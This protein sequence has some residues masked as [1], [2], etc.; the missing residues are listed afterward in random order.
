MFQ[1]Q[2]PQPRR[3]IL[4][5]N[6]PKVVLGLGAAIAIGSMV[7]FAAPHPYDIFIFNAAALIGG[8]GSD[9]LSKPLGPYA[10]YV[11]HA[12]LHGD[13]THLLLNLFALL[14]LGRSVA[15][16][17]GRS[18]AAAFGFLAFFFFC[19][20][21]GGVF[22]M[23]VFAVMGG[24]A[25]IGASSAISGLIPAFG[26]VRSGWSGAFGFGVGWFAINVAIAL[27]GESLGLP[28]AWAAHMGGLLAGFGF[29]IFLGLV[30]RA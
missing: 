10:P 18:R 25:A 29:P 2:S 7:W 19:A 4:A 27:F 11:F 26:Y 5:P 30:R 23:F 15:L 9:F 8:P 16:A 21:A 12:F 1:S 6:Y 28:I 14:V 17:F 3:P 13:L 24:G 22:Q 20:I